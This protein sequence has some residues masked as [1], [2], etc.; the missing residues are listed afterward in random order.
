[1][2]INGENLLKNNLMKIFIPIIFLFFGII[3]SSNCFFPN[4]LV[5]ALAN[6]TSVESEFSLE[7]SEKGVVGEPTIVSITSINPINKVYDGTNVINLEINIDCIDEGISVVGTGNIQ[8]ADVGEGKAVIVDISSLQLIGGSV[9]DYA[10][11]TTLPAGTLCVDITKMPVTFNWGVVNNQS[12]FDYTGKSLLNKINPYYLDINNVSHSLLI[13]V[14][15]NSFTSRPYS[16]NEFIN[17]GNYVVSIATRETDSNYLLTD[18]NFLTSKSFTISRIAPIFSFSKTSFTYLGEEQD[19][20]DYVSVNN[21]EQTISFSSET[22]RFTSYL[23]GEALIGIFVSVAQ[24][25]NYNSKSE[26]YSFNITKAQSS[27]DLSSLPTTLVYNGQVQTVNREL[28]SVNNLE[29]DI[30]VVV[31]DGKTLQNAGRYRLTIQTIE[32]DNYNAYINDYFY[33]DI[34]K[35]QIDVSHFSWQSTNNFTYEKDRSHSV[36]LNISST[37]VSPVYGGVYTATNAGIYVAQVNN[38]IV[39]DSDNTEVVGTTESL[40]WFISSRVQSIPRLTSQSSFTYDASEKQLSFNIMSNTYISVSNFAFTN[41]GNYQ[42]RIALIDDNVIWNDWTNDP[43]YIDWS[44]EKAVITIPEI[45]QNVYYNGETQSIPLEESELYDIIFKSG[46]SVGEYTSYIVLTDPA[47]YTFDV[48]DENFLL[49]SWQILE[50][51]NNQ[52]VSVIAIMMGVALMIFVCLFLTLQFTIN[53]RRRKKRHAE[54]M[55][56]EVL[57]KLSNKK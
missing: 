9:E 41:A 50:N 11:D 40:V 57:N 46:T 6:E 19:L 35:K 22:T 55:N 56:A 21:T 26:V 20:A 29:Q 33:V 53:S 31:N 54:I 15:G 2:V 5:F 39:T 43:I 36:A 49:V 16:L 52:S 45:T 28:I 18:S 17:P 27:I 12:T 47:N 7:T 8:T 24:S 23:E 30:S 4:E 10:L 38:Y 1:M 14:S 32:S 48:E 34:L 25:E 13:T 51:P 3:C 42:A 37:E 44:I